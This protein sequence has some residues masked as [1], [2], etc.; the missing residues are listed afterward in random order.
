M[1][2]RRAYWH[3]VIHGA[4]IMLLALAVLE[5]FFPGLGWKP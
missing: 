2:P 5:L 1:T 3:G 4:L